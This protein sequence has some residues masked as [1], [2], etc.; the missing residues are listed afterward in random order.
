MVRDA[1]DIIFV[2]GFDLLPGGI[3]LVW[4]LNDNRFIRKINLARG[5]AIEEFDRFSSVL[6]DLGGVFLQEMEA[7]EG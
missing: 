4:P 6:T 1:C 3:L 7:F 5:H 2:V